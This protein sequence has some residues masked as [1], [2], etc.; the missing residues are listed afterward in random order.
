MPL[1]SHCTE[2]SKR[3]WNEI[4]PREFWLIQEVFLSLWMVK[5]CNGLTGRAD[6]SF[7]EILWGWKIQTFI[8]NKGRR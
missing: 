5:P 7:L 8:V 4:A 3:K 1:I 2:Q 6:E